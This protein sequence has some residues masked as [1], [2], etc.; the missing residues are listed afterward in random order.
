MSVEEQEETIRSD[1]P[2][3]EPG[4]IVRTAIGEDAPPEAVGEVADGEA[5]PAVQG[6][7]IVS[8]TGLGS[9]ELG[10]VLGG[11]ATAITPGVGEPGPV[12]GM[13]AEVIELGEEIPEL[14]WDAGLA[15]EDLSNSQVEYVKAEIEGA[16]ING[17]E[18][19]RFGIE[20][21]KAGIEE[22]L[23]GQESAVAQGTEFTLE[24][25]EADSLEEEHAF[26]GI[27]EEDALVDDT[28][29]LDRDPSPAEEGFGDNSEIDL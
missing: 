21:V 20:M 2:T 11:G 3:V 6:E 28:A 23:V 26:G 7:E 17:E 12:R 27:G 4:G 5:I 29:L 15:V 1:I 13:E 9:E 14:K 8:V 10:G 25:V 16:D 22:E 19:A 24:V 18:S